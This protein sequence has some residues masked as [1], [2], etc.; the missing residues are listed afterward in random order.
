MSTEPNYIF[1]IYKETSFERVGLE[2]VLFEEELSKHLIRTG[3]SK[4][5]ILKD[6]KLTAALNE[7]VSIRADS[8]SYFEWADEEAEGFE[9][10]ED[11]G[12]YQR[13]V[14][15]PHS[16]SLSEVPPPILTEVKTTPSLKSATE[17]TEKVL[18][19]PTVKDS[20]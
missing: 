8:M 15:F 12:F 9:Y 5:D 17:K 16:H 14:E 2:S 20:Y 7:N 11:F 3:I 6:K 13:F 10:L 4:E 1:Y 18:T 19:P